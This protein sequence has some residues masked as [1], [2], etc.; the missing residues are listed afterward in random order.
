MKNVPKPMGYTV[1]PLWLF[2]SGQTRY[3]QKELPGLPG[4]RNIWLTLAI[5]GDCFNHDKFITGLLFRYC[6]KKYGVD[7][8]DE[9][10]LITEMQLHPIKKKFL[11]STG[12]V[13]QPEKRLLCPA[14][15]Y[16]L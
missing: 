7:S 11:V 5:A 8:H 10:G 2:S 12:A 15:K 14:Y 4:A 6:N 13:P 9:W 16:S 1:T 3:M